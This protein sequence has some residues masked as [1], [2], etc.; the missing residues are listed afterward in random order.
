M[1]ILNS[2]SQ[3][4]LNTIIHYRFWLSDSHLVKCCY[5][6]VFIVA[7]GFVSIDHSFRMSDILIC[8]N[9]HFVPAK[10]QHKDKKMT[11]KHLKD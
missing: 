6:A 3:L 10:T 7:Q 5:S 1:K 11:R 2:L 8:L 4:F 9:Y